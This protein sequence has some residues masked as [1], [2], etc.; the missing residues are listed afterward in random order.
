MHYLNTAKTEEERKVILNRDI[1]N[2]YGE[3]GEQLLRPVEMHERLYLVIRS[4]FDDGKRKEIVLKK[5]DFI[6][7]GR[8][9]FK[10]KDLYVAAVEKEREDRRKVLKR[11]EMTWKQKQEQEKKDCVIDSS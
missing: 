4:V 11:R 3:M 1:D 10:V 6:K 7:L 8:L 9:K 2:M 5:G